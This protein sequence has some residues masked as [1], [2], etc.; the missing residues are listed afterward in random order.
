MTSDP[1]RLFYACSL[2]SRVCLGGTM[3]HS[4]AFLILLS[5]SSQDGSEWQE[6]PSIATLD[7][8]PVKAK[9]I[10]Q[11]LI[12]SLKILSSSSR[13]GQSEEKFFSEVTRRIQ[14]VTSQH[15]ASFLFFQ[16]SAPLTYPSV[17]ISKSMTTS[18]I[19]SMIP[20]TQLFTA[21]ATD[22]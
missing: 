15:L 2:D 20:L 8:N 6:H 9:K 21:L 7:S 17:K 4:P 1:S 14:F 3:T 12:A 5:C 10:L 11:R 22:P 18:F 19:P 16:S 13:C